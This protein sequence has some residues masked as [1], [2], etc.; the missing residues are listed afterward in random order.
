ME[1]DSNIVFI[2]REDKKVG[3]LSRSRVVLAPN[4]L[5]ADELHEYTRSLTV[6]EIIRDYPASEVENLN[7]VDPTLPTTVVISETVMENNLEPGMDQDSSQ[8]S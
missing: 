8:G 2:V 1:T 5:T 7:E 4:Q 6:N 3:N